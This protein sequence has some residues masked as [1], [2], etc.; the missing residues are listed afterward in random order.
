MRR[1]RVCH[2]PVI[3]AIRQTEVVRTTLI[4]VKTFIESLSLGS[5]AT[6]MAI[7]S[8]LLVWPLCYVRPTILRWLGVVAVTLVLAYCLYWSPVWL[9]GNPSEYFSWAFL[10]IGA[11]FMAGAVPS[12]AVVL[13]VGKCRAKPHA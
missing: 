3:A 9:G 1:R 10:F 8:A 7:G 11:W 13:I 4:D 6:L 12:A 5:G 2:F